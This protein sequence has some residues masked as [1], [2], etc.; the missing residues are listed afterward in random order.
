[1]VL[2][3]TFFSEDVEHAQSVSQP[4]ATWNDTAPHGA[5]VETLILVARVVRVVIIEVDV[6]VAGLESD[7]SGEL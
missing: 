5:D 4:E 3:N 2:V 1:M 7:I 6:M